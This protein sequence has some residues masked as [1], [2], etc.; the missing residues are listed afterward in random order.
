MRELLEGPRVADVTAS[1]ARVE[2]DFVAG[3][4]GCAVVGLPANRWRS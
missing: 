3:Q 1:T 2:A 4:A